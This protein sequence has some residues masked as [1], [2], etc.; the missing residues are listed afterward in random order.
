VVDERLYPRLQHV[1]VLPEQLR[2]VLRRQL[3]A[4]ICRE[5]SNLNLGVCVRMRV[6]KTL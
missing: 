4:C 3:R 2:H 5:W 6:S 1:H